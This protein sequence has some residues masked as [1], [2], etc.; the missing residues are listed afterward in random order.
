MPQS[1]PSWLNELFRKADRAAKPVRRRSNVRRL[2]CELLEDRVVPAITILNAFNGGSLDADILDDGTVTIGGGTLSRG[3][4]ETASGNFTNITIT[5][6]GDIVFEDLSSTLVLANGGTFSLLANTG[7]VSF[8][9][10][11]NSV[12][13]ADGVFQIVASG[14]I[15]LAGLDVGA[16]SIALQADGN[17][18]VNSSLLAGDFG[19][20]LNADFDSD[21][22]GGITTLAGGTVLTTGQVTILGASVT[23]GDTID[24]DTVEVRSSASGIAFGADDLLISSGNIPEAEPNNTLAM[25]QVLGA[26]DTRVDIFGTGDGTYDYYSFFAEAGT[27]MEFETTTGNFD[28]ELFLFDSGRGLLAENDDFNVLLSF[29]QFTFATS[30]TY[31]IGVARFNSTGGTGGI[32]GATID[33]GQ[34]YTLTITSD[35]VVAPA[36]AISQFELDLITANFLRFDAAAGNIRLESYMV[37]GVDTLELAAAEIIDG[38]GGEQADLAVENLVLRATAV[39]AGDEIDVAVSQLAGTAANGQFRVANTGDLDIAE[40]TTA[41]GTV[42]GVDAGTGLINISSNFGI[43][44]LSEVRGGS[45]TLSTIDAATAGQDIVVD[46]GVRITATNLLRL[47]AGDNI[48]VNGELRVTTPV[49]YQLTI[50]AGNA[51]PAVGGTINLTNARFIDIR[52]ITLTG[53]NASDTFIFRADI[54][55]YAVNGGG[56]LDT[57]LIDLLND[58]NPS[59][60]VTA[61]GGGVFSF[62]SYTDITLTSVENLA[63]SI[64]FALELDLAVLGLQDGNAS[65]NVLDLASTAGGVLAARIQS[66]SAGVFTTVFG[67]PATNIS[68]ITIN[69]SSDRDTFRIDETNPG[70]PDI[71]LVGS[72]PNFAPGDTLD[73]DFTNITGQTLTPAGIGGGSFTFT[74]RND[75]VFTGIETLPSS[76]IVVSVAD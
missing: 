33:A 15:D 4:V 18:T 50:D 55:E 17:I 67:T 52:D 10:V 69:G 31:V 66:N 9:D 37:T 40:I 14:D 41:S 26:I 46:T 65:P 64:P 71:V 70:I 6:D 11:S 36:V 25:A 22:D 53:G 29:I 45:V 35:A 30:D 74:N 57:V 68:D 60:L 47:N 42:T 2:Q 8:D 62:G 34:V 49:A 63:P 38:T 75:I 19:I 7:S 56:G 1:F 5:S 54:S 76:D 39:G 32:S 48:T 3:A 20:V 23:L 21:G 72:G 43:F 59:L 12:T 24:A 73:I 16:G 44:V 13:L 61:P 51:D 27:T 28:T 58:V